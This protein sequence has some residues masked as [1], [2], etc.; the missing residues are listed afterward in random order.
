MQHTI[1]T[2][3]LILFLWM[4]QNCLAQHDTSIIKPDSGKFIYTNLRNGKQVT[5]HYY[6]P[7]K[8]NPSVIFVIPGAGRNGNTYRDAWI[9]HADQYNLL[10][11]SPEYD[12]D[13][14]PGF[15]NYNLAGMIKDVKIK[16]DRTGIESY[17]INTNNKEWILNDFDEL[18]DFIKKRLHLKAN[19]YDLFGHSAGGQ[20]LHRLA[21]FKPDNKA[22]RILASNAGWYTVPDKEA[23]FPYV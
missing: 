11:L 23:V 5:V 8:K 10:V 7:D 12:E 21:L 2:A 4:Y 9:P 3:F 17:N 18:F 22:N 14:Y 13:N 15:W 6:S 19:T 1:G 20:I 16:Q